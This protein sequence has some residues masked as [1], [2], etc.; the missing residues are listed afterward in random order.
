MNPPK[1]QL[2]FVDETPRADEAL[3]QSMCRCFA[4]TFVFYLKAHGYHWNVEGPDFG[5]FHAFF[6]LLYSEVYRTIDQM[7][8]EIRAIG[9]FVPYTLAEL[10]EHN[11]IVVP[12]IPDGSAALLMIEDL[13]SSNM[14]LIANLNIARK[15]AEDGEKF[16]LASYLEDRID[17]HEKHGWMLR[18]FLK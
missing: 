10:A 8:E 13:S 5:P 6:D 4:D 7:A 11:N 16:G 2:E 15:L 3:Y 1:I 9:Y 14:Q 18:S 17:Q 12:P